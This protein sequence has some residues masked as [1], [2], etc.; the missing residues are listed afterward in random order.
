MKNVG[1]ALFLKHIEEIAIQIY[2]IHSGNKNLTLDDFKGDQEIF[3]KDFDI[4]LLTAVSADSIAKIK[5]M[6]SEINRLNKK[7]NEEIEENSSLKEYIRI[8]EEEN[9]QTQAELETQKEDYAHL[10]SFLEVCSRS[11]TSST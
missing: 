1:G 10:T 9:K 8:L 7:L 2:K 11:I 3:E 4:H 5:S 6:S